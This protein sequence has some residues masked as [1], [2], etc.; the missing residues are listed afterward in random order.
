[1]LKICDYN[2]GDQLYYQYHF[3]CFIADKRSNID[4]KEVKENCEKF[5]KQYDDCVKEW[6]NCRRTR[7]TLNK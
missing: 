1:M 7:Y 5:K 2:C 6:Y 4:H 3:Y